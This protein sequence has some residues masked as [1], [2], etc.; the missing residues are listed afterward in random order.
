ML[1]KHKLLLPLYLTTHSNI[2]MPKQGL[3]ICRHALSHTCTH[4]FMPA[5]CERHFKDPLVFS[6]I[7]RTLTETFHRAGA[8]WGPKQ[9]YMYGT[10]QRWRSVAWTQCLRLHPKLQRPSLCGRN[11]ASACLMSLGQHIQQNRAC[12]WAAHTALVIY[13][14]GNLLVYS[15][16]RS[17]KCEAGCVQFGFKWN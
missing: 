11:G 4:A 5:V 12:V 15:C 8:T 6:V 3:W 14:S 13:R 17:E 2:A 1:S 10:L 7:L 16:K 9:V